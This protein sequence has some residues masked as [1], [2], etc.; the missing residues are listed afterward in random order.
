MLCQTNMDA[1]EENTP[2][3]REELLEKDTQD[4]KALSEA[5]QKFYDLP[6]GCTWKEITQELLDSPA[7]TEKQKNRILENGRKVYIFSYPSDGLKIKGIVSA[8]PRTQNPSTVVVLRGGNRLF[9]LVNPAGNILNTG[10]ETYIS[11]CYRDGVSE[12]KDEFGGNDV[13]DVKH[14]IDYIPEIEKQLDIAISQENMYLI[15]GSRGGMEM[16]LALSRFPELQDRFAKVVSLCGML[17]LRF[18]ISDRSDMREMFIED[19]GLIENIN[20]E[21]WINHRNPLNTVE[22]IRKDLPILIIQGTKDI[23]VTLEE[24]RHMLQKLQDNGNA[25]TYLE[26]PDADHCLTNREDRVEIILDWLKQ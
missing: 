17:D 14:L 2:L 7:I 4:T 12:G 26:I 18:C 21:E 10:T 15:G 8:A 1:K 13:N 20:E 16:F 23:R 19:F 25:V 9:G 5:F 24:G 6:D 11:T 22:K 3:T